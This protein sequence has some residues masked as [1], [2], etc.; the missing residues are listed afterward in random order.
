MEPP[1]PALGLARSQ[2][3]Q[4][5]AGR[6][7]FTHPP[8]QFDVFSPARACVALCPSW[9]PLRDT[10]ITEILHTPCSPSKSGNALTVVYRRW[11]LLTP[12]TSPPQR[13][14]LRNPSRPQLYH[15]SIATQ[16][17]PP[18]IFGPLDSGATLPLLE[19]KSNS[20]RSSPWY[21]LLS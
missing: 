12:A 11:R 13:T 7:R 8:G 17:F 3:S 20:G 15:G 16:D 1:Y 9:L 19:W 2:W 21:A 10:E 4:G 5:S 14:T 6:F 18:E